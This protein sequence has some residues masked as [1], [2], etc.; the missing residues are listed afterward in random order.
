MNEFEILDQED[1][2]E[3]FNYS[4]HSFNS[5]IIFIGIILLFF[6]IMLLHFTTI[7]NPS[8]ARFMFAILGL[9]LIVNGSYG[10][11]SASRSLLN[12]EKNS[13][14]KIIGLVGNGIILLLFIYGLYSISKII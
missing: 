6:F 11:I 8:F 3:K 4:Q 2:E 14:K 10:I 7:I 12:K 5:L 13:A 1:A 9:T